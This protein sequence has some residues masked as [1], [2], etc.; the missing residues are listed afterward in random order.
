M[1][2]SKMKNQKI[3]S[4]VVGAAGEQFAHVTYED[5]V[6]TNDELL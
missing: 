5:I 6:K 3:Q 2:E 4:S 1:G